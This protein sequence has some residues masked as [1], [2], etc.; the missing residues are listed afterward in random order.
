M[1]INVAIL[2]AQPFVKGLSEPQLEMPV[3][4][5]MPMQFSAGQSIFREGM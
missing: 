5:F 3:E 4:N 2:A 1:T